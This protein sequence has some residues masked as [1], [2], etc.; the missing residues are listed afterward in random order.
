M[1]KMIL[2]GL[3]LGTLGGCS[4]PTRETF[5]LSIGQYVGA[6]VESLTAVIGSPE[7]THETPSGRDYVYRGKI[8]ATGLVSTSGTYCTLNVHTDQSNII[9]SIDQ[10]GRQEMAP[11]PT[12]DECAW[13]FGRQVGANKQ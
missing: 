2:L 12:G 6:S 1:N 8:E 5:D 4:N 10:S 9:T 13:I 11:T 7:T 3:V